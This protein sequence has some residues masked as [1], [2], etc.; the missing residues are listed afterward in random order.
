MLGVRIVARVLVLPVRCILN[1]FGDA[2]ILCGGKSERMQFD[3][4]FAK[5]NGSYMIEIIYEKLSQCFDHVKLCADSRERLSMFGLDTIVD[6]A[7]AGAG[8]G[9]ALGIYSA[10]SQATSNYVFVTACDMPLIDVDHIHFMKQL[11]TQSDTMPDALVPMCRG[12]IEPLYSFYSTNMVK[13]IEEE[14]EQGNNKLHS[15]LSKR[16]VIYMEEMHSRSFS[17]DLTMFHN[18]NTKEDLEKASWLMKSE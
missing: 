6:Q 10:L 14:L 9:P 11:L 15:I 8:A 5:I 17:P 18:I 2:V 13:H 4:A 3:K 1:L 7:P 16:N 12:F